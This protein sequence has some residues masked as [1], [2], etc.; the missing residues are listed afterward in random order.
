MSSDG[1]KNGDIMMMMVMHVTAT[2]EE[3]IMYDA[4]VSKS[5]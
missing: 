5:E 3:S 4:R 1:D 2:V